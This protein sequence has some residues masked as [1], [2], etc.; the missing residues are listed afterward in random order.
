MNGGQHK[1]SERFGDEVIK[2][3]LV[4]SPMHKKDAGL[5]R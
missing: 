3:V 2:D 1:I 4:L 5:T